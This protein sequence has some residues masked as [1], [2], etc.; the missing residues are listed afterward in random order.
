[1]CS[2]S[3]LVSED[4]EAMKLSVECPAAVCVSGGG[5]R[6]AY[7]RLEERRKR[8][9]REKLD[10]HWGEDVGVKVLCWR[11]GGCELCNTLARPAPPA[12]PSSC[13]TKVFTAVKNLP[14]EAKC[15]FSA[16]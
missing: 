9:E 4:G 10:A 1:M 6:M 3:R 16:A 7:T 13:C 14:C 15:L 5:A 12:P 11:G 8:N 2:F